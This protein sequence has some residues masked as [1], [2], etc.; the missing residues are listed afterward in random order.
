MAKKKKA[1]AKK[2]KGATTNVMPPDDPSE[3]SPYEISGSEPEAPP[4]DPPDTEPG[5]SPE[6]SPVEILKNV[7]VNLKNLK[8]DNKKLRHGIVVLEQTA[9]ILIT[10]GLDE[11]GIEWPI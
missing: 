11:A 6:M 5:D 7:V 4:N 8:S 9:L 2:F 1:K 10:E 3:A